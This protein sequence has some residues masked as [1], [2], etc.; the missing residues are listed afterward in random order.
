MG[1][2]KIANVDFVI[3]SA[4]RPAGGAFLKNITHLLKGLLH[5]KYTKIPLYGTI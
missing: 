2:V 3:M 1:N 4:N 5:L